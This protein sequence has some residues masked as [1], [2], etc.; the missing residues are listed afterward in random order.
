MS[1]VTDTLATAFS[2]VGVNQT[3]SAFQ[4]VENAQ[5]RLDEANSKAGAKPS[6]ANKRAVHEAEISLAQLQ[7]RIAASVATATVSMLREIAQAAEEA[8][9]AYVDFGNQVMSIRDLTGATA[10]QSAQAVTLFRAAGIKD[11]MQAREILQLSRDEFSGKGLSALSMLGISGNTQQNGLALFNQIADALQQLPP[12]IQKARIETDLF[13]M[14]GVAA[15]GPLLRM[16]HEQRAAFE[17]LS[18]V[19]ESALEVVQQYD[20]AVALLG[21]T[22]EQKV[23]FPIVSLV[24]PALVKLIAA[25][26]WAAGVFGVIQQ[27]TNG[28]AGFVIV[29]AA[30]SAGVGILIVALAAL[31][32]T[33]IFQNT[34][35]AIRAALSGPAGWTALAVAAGVA[36]IGAIGM[37]TLGNAAHAHET[38]Q[39]AHTSAMNTHAAALQRHVD[40]LSSLNHGGRPEGLTKWDVQQ[41]AMQGALGAIG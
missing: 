22:W 25:L 4:Q 10:S 34:L 13:G 14:R 9:K 21:A 20:I 12:G 1:L 29:L 37:V 27:A 19:N 41:L 5:R 35:L 36:G 3:V 32:T 33:L 40:S 8:T 11:A 30:M 16:T 17:A 7:E 26:T 28:W 6:G 38:S 31:S 2:V 18:S 23:V 24:L 15:L 39:N